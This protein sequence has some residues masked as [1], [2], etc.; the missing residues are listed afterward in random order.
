MSQEDL[1][2]LAWNSLLDADMNY[3][4]FGCLG[5]RLERAN[6]RASIFVAV[7]ASTTV[8]G[9]AIWGKEGFEWLWQAASAAS[10]LAALALPFFDLP[11]KL[12][13]CST[14]KGAWFSILRDYELLWA[15][16]DS[17]SEAAGRA[18][19][20]V[21]MKEE[22]DLIELEAPFGKDVKLV[23]ACQDDVIRAR[24]LVSLDAKGNH[25]V[26]G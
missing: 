7:T 8:S 4:Y 1:K 26:S 20:A 15:E 24:G 23:R 11:N 19:L 13:S 21:S 14:L 22:K 9:W 12:K 16:L 18:R 10:A 2:A 6:R 17:L 3:R 5:S 25:N